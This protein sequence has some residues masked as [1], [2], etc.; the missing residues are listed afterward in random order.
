MI[1]ADSIFYLH[2]ANDVMDTKPDMWH[3]ID[4]AIPRIKAKWNYMAYSMGYGI[5]AVNAFERD[6]RDSEQSCLN[7]FEDWLSTQNGVTP[8]TWRKLLDR[9]KAVDGLQTAAEDIEKIISM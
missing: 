2:I 9:I 4:I 5:L 1:I 7:L 8:K 3:I 6:S